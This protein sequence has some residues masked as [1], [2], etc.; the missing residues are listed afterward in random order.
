MEQAP[1]PG[2]DVQVVPADFGAGFA[3]AV[4][5]NPQLAAEVAVQTLG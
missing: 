2:L 4:A 3:G 5:V 1:E